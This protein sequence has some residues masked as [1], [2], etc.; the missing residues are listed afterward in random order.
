MT[1]QNF[2]RYPMKALAHKMIIASLGCLGCIGGMVA[3]QSAKAIEDTGAINKNE[4]IKEI[5]VT[6]TRLEE[7]S[8]RTAWSVTR[9]EYSDL[10]NAPATTFDRILTDVPGVTLFR[11]ASS[12]AAHPT[13]QGVTLRGIG[14]NG[15]GRALVTLDGV[16]L[17]DP[18]GGWVTWS[19]IDPARIGAVE[20]QRGGGAGAMGN[21]ALT[22]H[23][24]LESRMP[25]D[26]DLWGEARGGNF[27]TVDVSAGLGDRIGATAFSLSGRYFN[28]DG[29]N[30]RPEDQRGPVD[31]PA[32]LET[33]SIDA[34]GEWQIADSTTLRG[35][36][37]W[38]REEGVNGL[39]LSTNKTD[40]LDLSLGLVIDGGR[41]GP[42]LEIIGWYHDRDFANSFAAVFDEARTV[43]RQVLDQF[44]VPAEGMGGN[45]ILRLP[46]AE[47]GVLEFG[48]DL[49]RLEGATNELFRNLGDGF[50]R[51]RQAGGDQWLIG[52]WVEYAGS[53]T[54]RLEISSG[55][56]LDYWKTFDGFLQESDRADGTILRDDAIT[57]RSDTLVNGRLALAYRLHEKLRLRLSGYTG[58]R[59]PTIN[60]FFRPFRVGN[61]ITE[62]NPNLT[63][64]RLYGTELGLELSVADGVVVSATYFRNWLKNGVGNITLAEGPGVFPPAGF[65]PAG[66]SLRQRQNIERIIADGIELEAR[67]ALPGDLALVARYLFTD[68]RITQSDDFPALVGNRL[69]QSAKHSAA[70]DLRWEPS[71]PWRLSLS[72]RTEGD[73][74][75]DDLGSRT[76]SGFFTLDAAVFYEIT[77]TTELFVSAENV[78]DKA[79]ASQID[80]DGLLTRARPRLVSGGVRIGL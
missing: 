55:V 10:R 50:T 72:A 60:E 37:G 45:A 9:L 46:I 40:A 4:D 39:A 62:A 32:A 3:A 26:F 20:I 2:A 14:P 38:F 73:R 69:A 68:A 35:R 75:E 47:D 31:V 29:F 63:A 59:L 77:E 66:G 53:L 78:F 1:D 41:L 25:E 43:E 56:R 24:Q 34:R 18:F 7:P 13:T 23:I 71:L 49:R 11:R 61:D 19:A 5:A 74:F 67:A 48:T 28:S 54:E 33:G 70:L 79:I 44:D 57:D 51:L 21:Q 22:G 52:G 65:V 76:L 17:N 15:A 16:P 64:E 27:G 80:G 30:L 12:L 36:V 6:T 58:F 8:A 42:S